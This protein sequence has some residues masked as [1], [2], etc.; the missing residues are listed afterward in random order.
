VAEWVGPTGVNQ[1]YFIPYRYPSGHVRRFHII[2]EMV[3]GKTR[4]SG[5]RM[6]A[7]TDLFRIMYEP[8]WDDMTILV[9]GDDWARSQSMPG[10][11]KQG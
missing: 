7:S 5:E 3:F 2:S 4:L 6:C 1:A 10:V 11:V 8:V 9:G